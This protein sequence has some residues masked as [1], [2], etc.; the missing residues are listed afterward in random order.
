VKRF[1]NVMI[2]VS[3]K[4]GSMKDPARIG[5]GLSPLRASGNGTN[6]ESDRPND[7]I[8]LATEMTAA[9]DPIPLRR[10]PRLPTSSPDFRRQTVL[11]EK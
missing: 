3:A 7:V 10:Q 11:D 5:S 6:L 8:H 9:A 2:G 1:L 4:S